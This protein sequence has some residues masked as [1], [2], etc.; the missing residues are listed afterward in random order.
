[1]STALLFL[2]KNA[3]DVTLDVGEDHIVMRASSNKDL[4]YEL[5]IFLPIDIDPDRTTAEFHKADQ[6]YVLSL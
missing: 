5:D 2:K 6:V 3:T 4:I 1:M